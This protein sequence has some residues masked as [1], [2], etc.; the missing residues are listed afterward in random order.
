[1]NLNKEFT[2]KLKGQLYTKSFPKDE[3]DRKLPETLKNVLIN[4]L[5]FS[6]TRD[7]KEVFY[8]NHIAEEIIKCENDE[9]VLREPYLK[10]LIDSCYDAVNREDSN[11]GKE[12]GIYM[13]HL[14]SQ[15]LEEL[16]EKSNINN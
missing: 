1:M 8:V 4:I 6:K 7:R 13:A 10:F 11:T 15:I 2:N 16:G 9:F 14:M 5:A 12:P 3:E